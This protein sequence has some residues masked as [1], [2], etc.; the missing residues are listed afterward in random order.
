MR[1]I[2]VA[3]GVLVGAVSVLVCGSAGKA[4]AF[5]G[6]TAGSRIYA[7][8]T[9]YVPSETTDF[10]AVKA[11]WVQPSVTCTPNNARVRFAVGLD[12]YWNFTADQDYPIEQGGS[13][14]HCVRGVPQYQLFWGMSIDS[15]QTMRTINPGD[16]ITASVVYDPGTQIFTIKV[17]DVTSGAGFFRDVPCAD[18]SSCP[19]SSANVFS[20]AVGKGGGKYFGLADYGTMQFT[21][22]TLTDVNGTT[23]TFSNPAWINAAVTQQQN[24][25][26]YA[27]VSPLAGS[28]FNLTW[29]HP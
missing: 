5:G 28:S 13:S 26:T 16:T 4:Q 15:P 10:N 29:Q 11:T 20:E 24:K 21:D 23:D 1:R 9:A 3:S 19:R 17:R 2:A 6:T 27:A 7:G 22:A 18:G 14:V 8:Y 25:A 12:G